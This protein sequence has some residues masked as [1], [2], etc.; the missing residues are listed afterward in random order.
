MI[1]PNLKSSEFGGSA[2]AWFRSYLKG[3][4]QVIKIKENINGITMSTKR[5]APLSVQE[6]CLKVWVNFCF[7]CSLV[8]SKNYLTDICSIQNYVEEL[9][10]STYVS[11]GMA[12]Q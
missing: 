4:E 12:K 8:T 1:I 7:Y 3:R 2:L 9:K 6:K 11:I 10:I 5:S